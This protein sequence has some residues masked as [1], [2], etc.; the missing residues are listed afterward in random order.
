VAA[1]LALTTASSCLAA[2]GGGGSASSVT[3]EVMRARQA[4]LAAQADVTRLAT[5]PAATT[6]LD[7][8]RVVSQQSAAGYR[9]REAIRQEQTLVYR[10]AGDP[11]L[12]AEVVAAI[13]AGGHP[14]FQDA[15]AALGASW[16]ASGVT[17]PRLVRPHRDRRYLSSEPIDTLLGYYRGAGAQFGIDW[18]VLAAINFIESDFGR[19]LG[20]SAAGAMGPMQFLPTTWAE[21]GGGGDIMSPHDSIVAAARYLRRGGAPGDYTGALHAYN[22]DADYVESVQRFAAAIR[23]D[24]LWLAR[25]YYWSTYG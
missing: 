4:I 21:V 2:D 9:Y 1:A 18:T 20:P 8:A 6:P 22:H 10:L 23:A 14:G 5:A 7:A 15:L 17:Q 12:A 3:Q 25:L 19:T 11:G 16:R 13:P 24:P